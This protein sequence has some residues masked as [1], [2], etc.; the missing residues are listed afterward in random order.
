MIRL[1]IPHKGIIELHHAI[2]DV[3]GTIAV[4]GTPI[5]GVVDQLKTLAEKLSIHI[6]TGGTHGNIPELEKAFGYPLQIVQNAQEKT[7]YVQKLDPSTVIAFG[8][9]VIDVGMLRLAAVGVAVIATEGLAVSAL[10]AA[11]VLAFGPI[12]AINMVLKPKRLVATLRG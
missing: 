11:D 1:D 10:Q 5:P 12:D 4:D 3:N 7:E 2:F 8:N 9:G 6:L